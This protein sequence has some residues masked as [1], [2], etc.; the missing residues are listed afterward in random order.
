[1]ALHTHKYLSET[2]SAFEGVSWDALAN[3]IPY[4]VHMPP[5]HRKN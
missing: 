5:I 2:Q 3:P 4:P 1:M